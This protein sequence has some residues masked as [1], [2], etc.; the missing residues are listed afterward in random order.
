MLMRKGVIEVAWLV[1]PCANATIDFFTTHNNMFTHDRNLEV[2]A[3]PCGFI[4]SI[5]LLKPNNSN[6][7]EIEIIIVV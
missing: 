3:R 2:C 1:W 6:D 7:P 4:P 5:I